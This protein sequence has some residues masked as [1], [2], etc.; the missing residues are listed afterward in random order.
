MVVNGLEALCVTNLC[1]EFLKP[2]PGSTTVLI[3]DDIARRGMDK[4][5]QTI[6]AGHFSVVLPMSQ[7]VFYHLCRLR[8]KILAGAAPTPPIVCLAKAETRAW[9]PAPLPKL[10]LLRL[11]FI[12]EDSELLGQFTA[13]A[14]PVPS[15]AKQGS[16]VAVGKA[17]FL[18]TT[19]PAP[20]DYAP[21][22]L[23][24]V[25]R[26]RRSAALRSGC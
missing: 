20:F 19:Q 22:S 11:G 6:A 14:R 12:D 8:S 18:V 16:Y 10:D 13:A 21:R 1:N 17:L 23:S 24:G 26:S 7:Q 5:V 2:S 4:T 15:K 9:E 25:K 3:P